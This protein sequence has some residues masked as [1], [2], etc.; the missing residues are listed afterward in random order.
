[1]VTPL[2]VVA[3]TEPATDHAALPVF[4]NVNVTGTALP[5]ES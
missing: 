1:M 4:V 2:P 5:S 3:G